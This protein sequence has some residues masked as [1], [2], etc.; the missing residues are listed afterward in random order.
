MDARG[1]LIALAFSVVAIGACKRAPP[2]PPSVQDA[3]PVDHLAPGEVAEGREKAYALALPQASSVR[4]RFGGTIGVVSTLSPEQLSNFVR[5]RVKEGRVVTGTSST[6][7]E[8]VIVPSE[9]QRRLT[10][11]VRP[12]RLVDGLRSEMTV[13]DVTPPPIEPNLTEEERWKKAGLTPDG[14]PLD[15]KH[16]E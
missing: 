5:A 7:F 8:N 11:D 2:P 4:T 13:Q 16:L 9:P 6:R 12:S 3:G 10:I 15:P 1:R 14:R